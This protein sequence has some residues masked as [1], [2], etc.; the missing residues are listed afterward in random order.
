[1]GHLNC[2]KQEPPLYVGVRTERWPPVQTVPAGVYLQS[3]Y[4]ACSREVL[5]CG[6]VVVG[7]SSRPGVVPLDPSPA[8]CGAAGRALVGVAWRLNESR[9]AE[10]W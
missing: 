3:K 2:N 1:M 8:R 4:V 5:S 10:A 6:D 9:G 7:G